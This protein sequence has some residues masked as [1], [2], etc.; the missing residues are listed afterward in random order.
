MRKEY[1]TLS[2]YATP[3]QKQ[4]LEEMSSLN[5]K[6]KSYLIRLGLEKLI[7]MTGGYEGNEF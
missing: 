6:S 1:V 2:F 3:K 4:W 7:E 5:G